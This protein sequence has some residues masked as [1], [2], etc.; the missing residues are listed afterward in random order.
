MDLDDY[1]GAPSGLG[2]RAAEWADKPHRLIYD[3][4]HIA[5][6]EHAEV[7]RH[8]RDFEKIRALIAAY[9]MA[10]GSGPPTTALLIR[11]IRN[12]VG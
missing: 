3:L 7:E 9:E 2:P 10:M 11:D 4:I 8:H 12:I 6:E 1:K 5:E